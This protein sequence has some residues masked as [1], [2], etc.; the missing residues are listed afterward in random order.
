MRESPEETLATPPRLTVRGPSKAETSYRA[1]SSTLGGLKEP[2][3]N[4]TLL[5]H[6]FQ[7]VR[8]LSVD[9]TLYRTN[10]TEPAALL[11]PSKPLPSGCL[12]HSSLSSRSM[13]RQLPRA[14]PRAPD[15]GAMRMEVRRTRR[16][17]PTLA[18][19]LSPGQPDLAVPQSAP[20][21]PSASSSPRWPCSG[22]GQDV[23]SV[24]CLA[25]PTGKIDRC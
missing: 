24:S 23:P 22:V 8:A 9:E 1:K 7:S 18:G 10:R 14:Q 13:V 3:P 15:S 5:V 21:I 19:R 20:I 17:E 16:S 4:R 6:A 11:L 25:T 2:W 12:H